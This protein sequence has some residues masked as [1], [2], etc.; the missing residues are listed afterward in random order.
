[1]K[2]GTPGSHYLPLTSV[3]SGKGA[4]VRP[5]VYVFTT[6]IVNVV[7]VG[8]PN[9][10]NWVLVDAGMPKSDDNIM[11]AIEERFGFPAPPRAIVLT[12]GHFD[13][14]GALSVLA[15]R[16]D[17]PVYAHELEMPYLTGTRAYPEPDPLVEGGLAAKLSAFFPN[18]PVDLTGRVKPLP[19]DGTVPEMPGWRWI[20]TPGHTLGH[21]SLFREE[22]RT[23]IAGDAFVTVRQDKLYQ[24]LTQHLEISGPPRYYTPDWIAAK[25]S[26]RRL[27]ALKPAA[28][29]TG[30]GHP[31]AGRELTEGLAELARD[32][33]RLAVPDHGKYVD[34]E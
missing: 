28:A 16:W 30:H 9:T 20:H 12:H 7:L 33:D 1:M 17:V 15:S 8:A 10:L 4:E 13:H 14:V 24:V 23:L 31:V 22:D 6:Q 5:D 2:N 27:E 21:V 19:A 3:S 34:G 11:D 26:V 32:F 18:E 25:E 29:V